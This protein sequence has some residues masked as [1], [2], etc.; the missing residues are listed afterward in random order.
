MCEVNA[1]EN[2]QKWERSGDLC[3]GFELLDPAMLE[4]ITLEQELLTVWN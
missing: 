3:T 2:G 1:E 4:A